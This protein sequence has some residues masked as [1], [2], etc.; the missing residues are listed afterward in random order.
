M[1]NSSLLIPD[2]KKFTGYKPCIPGKNC[3]K[4]CDEIER[5]GVVILIINLDAMGDVL[6]TT[7]QLKSIKEKY[8]D[9]TIYWLTMKNAAQLLLHNNY[10]DK[11]IVWNFESIL[12][13]QQIKFDV[14]LNADKSTQS[15]S[16]VNSLISGQKFGFGL[17]QNGAI[18]PLSKAADYNYIL[19]LDDELKFRK[20]LRTGQDILSETFELNYN[21]DEYVLNLTE[22]EI[23]FCNEYKKKNH[24]HDSDLVVG[25]NTGCSELYPNKK[26]T[27]DQHVYLIEKLSLFDKIKLVLLG[28]PEDTRRNNQIA[29]YVGD[30][31]LLTPTTEGLRRGIC[32]ENIA[33]I[34]ITGDSFG[35]HLA[36]ALKKHVIAWF[37]LSCWTE[38][39]LYDR[40]IKMIPNGLKCSP[41]WKKVCP[42][43]LEC[44]K[45]IDLDSII[46]EVNS[47]REKRNRGK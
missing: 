45:M 7:A 47:Y 16:L 22:E 2:C 27:V 10:I 26:M 1:V 21:R 23:S 33:D 9:S 41:C 6:M 8:P 14:I 30:K 4:D 28:G 24:I 35:M 40:G 39:D 38:I 15:C 44:I 37:G 20:N 18:I 32:Y 3:L 29:E 42:Y 17:N 31:V 11:V 19:G 25:F 13:L 12:L 34:I 5:K 36:I 43:D 46:S